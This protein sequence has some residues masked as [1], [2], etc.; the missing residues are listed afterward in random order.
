ML[1]S[2]LL[3]TMPLNVTLTLCFIDVVFAFK[4]INN[5]NDGYSAKL[6]TSNLTVK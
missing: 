2:M 1:L 3:I 6:S 4:P 5:G